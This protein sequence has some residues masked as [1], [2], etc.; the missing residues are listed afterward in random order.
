MWCGGCQL[1]QLAES[2]L[3]NPHWGWS[4]GPR[5]LRTAP[6]PWLPDTATGGCTG[7]QNPSKSRL[8]IFSQW[9]LFNKYDR[10]ELVLEENL[11]KNPNRTL[12]SSDF[13]VL[14]PSKLNWIWND[15]TSGGERGQQWQETWVTEG[16]R[17][18]PGGSCRSNLE[19]EA[20]RG[21]FIVR[22]SCD[23]LLCQI[24]EPESEHWAG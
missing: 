9:F 5:R 14:L 6:K 7:C 23:D 1:A 16:Y 17:A 24:R 15:L 13:Y 8:A 3:A 2:G 18:R 19:A 4:C 12:L 21:R 10:I 20:G 22:S 11:H